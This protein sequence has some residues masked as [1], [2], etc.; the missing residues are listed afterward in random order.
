[1][2]PNS[3][4]RI[5]QPYA[6]S[7]QIRAHLFSEA[8][9]KFVDNNQQELE[10]D[11][12]LKLAAYKQLSEVLSSKKDECKIAFPDLLP[13]PDLLTIGSLKKQQDILRYSIKRLRSVK[14]ALF[15]SDRVIKTICECLEEYKNMVKL[16]DY[17]L[18]MSM[19]NDGAL[20]I[21]ISTDYE[22]CYG[23]LGEFIRNELGKSLKDPQLKV[24]TKLD[25]SNIQILMHKRKKKDKEV[26]LGFD[27]GRKR[28]IIRFVV[29]FQQDFFP[30]FPKHQHGYADDT[31]ETR[32]LTDYALSVAEKGRI[33]KSEDPPG[34]ITAEELSLLVG[35]F[36]RMNRNYYQETDIIK[37]EL[38]EQLMNFLEQE[39]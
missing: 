35:K 28:K 34:F 7:D 25:E 39:I 24:L 20:L 23:E 3:P 13:I 30:C 21:R 33:L 11:F 8:I 26:H 5:Y 1:M 14:R 19:L 27:E 31:I 36:Q 38:M 22:G 15:V 37:E 29:A 10:N 4:D 32:I 16:E 2:N 12:L 9:V 17:F 18:R 6:S